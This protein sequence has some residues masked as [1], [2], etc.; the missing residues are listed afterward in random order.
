MPSRRRRRRGRARYAIS[1]PCRASAAAS[2]RRRRRTRHIR[3][4][5]VRSR[6]GVGD[7]IKRAIGKLEAPDDLAAAV[8][9][10]RFAR[11]LAITFAHAE[12]AGRLPP[13]HH[14]PFDRMLVAQALTKRLSMVTADD[15][16]GRY[17]VEIVRAR[18]SLAGE[19]TFGYARGS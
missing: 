9:A 1:A 13:H 16:I 14:D 12:L 17:G 5:V 4:I 19:H 2:R 3:G 8:A 15:R 7:S 11:S 18:R 6:L 10:S